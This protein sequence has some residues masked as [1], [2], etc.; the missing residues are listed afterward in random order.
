[1]PFS[2]VNVVII[3]RCFNYFMLRKELIDHFS[4]LIFPVQQ[5]Q[6]FLLI[7]QA[8]SSIV[9]KSLINLLNQTKLLFLDAFSANLEVAT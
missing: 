6:G 8:A 2:T 5:I 4:D 1:M 3:R 9:W 7:A